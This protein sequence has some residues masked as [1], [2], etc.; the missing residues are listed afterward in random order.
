MTAAQSGIGAL[1]AAGALLTPLLRGCHRD[2]LGISFPHRCLAIAADSAAAATGLSALR[3]EWGWRVLVHRGP[4]LV[5]A[6]AELSWGMDGFVLGAIDEGATVQ[7][8][9]AAVARTEAD[10][11]VC[12]EPVLLMS[13]WLGMAGLWV[14]DSPVDER[15]VYLLDGALYERITGAAFASRLAGEAG[16][17]SVAVKATTPNALS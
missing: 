16:R 8:T 2:A 10:R 17:R 12:G 4:A 3:G 1:A 11:E 14:R 9:V 5:A 7:R 6:A 13:R 15:Y